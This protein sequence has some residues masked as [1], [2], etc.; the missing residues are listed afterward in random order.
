MYPAP[1]GL[2]P[3]TGALTYVGNN[4]YNWSSTVSGSDARRLYF[5]V[6]GL[7]PYSADYRAFGFPVRCLQE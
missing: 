5:H 3:Y 7:N 4:G 6:T 2:Y 1:G